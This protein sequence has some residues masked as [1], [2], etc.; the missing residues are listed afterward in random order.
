MKNCDCIKITVV[1]EMIK[2]PSG[3]LPTIVELASGLDTSGDILQSLTRRLD[4]EA[5]NLV[6]DIIREH[7]SIVVTSSLGKHWIK[8]LSRRVNSRRKEI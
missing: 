5:I 8:C 4:D 6:L 7:L 3:R 2:E 1:E